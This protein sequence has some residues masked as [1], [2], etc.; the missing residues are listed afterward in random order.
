MISK[1]QQEIKF[2]IKRVESL[3]LQYDGTEESLRDHKTKNE[4]L[5]TKLD[6]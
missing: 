2:Y 4:I 1:L 3:T 5:R 6:E